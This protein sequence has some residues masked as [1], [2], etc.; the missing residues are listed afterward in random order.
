MYPKIITAKAKNQAFK[1]KLS[2]WDSVRASVIP[3]LRKLRQEVEP[4]TS[5]GYIFRP[6]LNHFQLGLL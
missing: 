5:L 3:D 1:E 2:R 6:E 4:Q